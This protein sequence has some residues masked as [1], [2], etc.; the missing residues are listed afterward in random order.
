MA[1]LEVGMRVKIGIL[2]ALMVV[3][4]LRLV[5]VCVSGLLVVL[6]CAELWLIG[7]VNAGP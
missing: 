7:R 5:V 4:V 6:E 1:Q 3:C 2:S